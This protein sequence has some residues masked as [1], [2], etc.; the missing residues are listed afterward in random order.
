MCTEKTKTKTKTARR[1]SLSTPLLFGG[2]LFAW[3]KSWPAS[4]QN[5]DLLLMSSQTPSISYSLTEHPKSWIKWALSPFFLQ[6]FHSC[7]V[8]LSLQTPRTKGHP[9]PQSPLR[10]VCRSVMPT[11]PLSLHNSAQVWPLVPTGTKLPLTLHSLRSNLLSLRSTNDIPQIPPSH[12]FLAL[13]LAEALN[14]PSDQISFPD[15]G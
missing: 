11:L 10:Q 8:G 3:L 5:S 15:M 6:G 14:C 4:R 9:Q 12:H 1:P 13:K 7:W 2:R